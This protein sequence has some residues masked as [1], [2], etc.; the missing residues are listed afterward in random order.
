M[1]KR[2]ILAEP[3]PEPGECRPPPHLR[4]DA[5]AVWESLAPELERRGLLAPRYAY[6][7]EVLCTCIAFYRQA[8]AEL[9]RTGLL[10]EGQRGEQV[11]HPASREVARFAN[12]VRAYGSDFGL[13]PSAVTA[14]ARSGFETRPSCGP[15]RLLS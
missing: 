9:A 3:T 7:F 2:R 8:A 1:G 4:P 12:L 14:V 15:G 11:S 10:A 6:T 13:S 5:R